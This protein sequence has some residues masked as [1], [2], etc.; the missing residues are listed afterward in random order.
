MPSAWAQAAMEVQK[1]EM[2]NTGQVPP[3][4]AQPAG[5]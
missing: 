4:G 1:E 2:G 3:Q 5:Q